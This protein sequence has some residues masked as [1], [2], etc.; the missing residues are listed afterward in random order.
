MG[1]VNEYSR[2]KPFKYGKPVCFIVCEGKNQTEFNYLNNFK[3]RDGGIIVNPIKCE[4]TDPASMIKR[5]KKVKQESDYNSRRGDK[6]VCLIDIDGKEEKAEIVKELIGK[7][8]DIIIIRSNPC[9]ESW[10]LF[11]YIKDPPYC[12]DGDAAKSEMKKYCTPY[13][14]N[15]DIFKKEPTFKSQTR[16]AIRRSKIKKE[17]AERKG[18]SIDNASAN[19][20]TDMDE[21]IELILKNNNIDLS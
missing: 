6:L 11:H 18:Y 12:K 5:A 10:F 14:E 9:V 19:P 8:P 4:A 15:Y 1:K 16:E 21:L 20:Y 3:V 13:E 7:N 17:E 2:K